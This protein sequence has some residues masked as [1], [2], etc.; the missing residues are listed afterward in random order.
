MFHT[1]FSKEIEIRR[2]RC[3]LDPL[4]SPFHIHGRPVDTPICIDNSILQFDNSVLFVRSLLV[5]RSFHG[6]QEPGRLRQKSNNKESYKL[7]LI[8][9]IRASSLSAHGAYGP[10]TALIG[11]TRSPSSSCNMKFQKFILLT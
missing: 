3:V 7:T 8:L 10:P 5:V 2:V 11:S 9:F 6:L 1:L 4:I